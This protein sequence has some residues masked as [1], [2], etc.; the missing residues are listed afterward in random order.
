[1]YTSIAEAVKVYR[2]ELEKMAAW[3]RE[4][5]RENAALP[6]SELVNR[7]TIANYMQRTSKLHGMAAVL[8]LTQEENKQLYASAG[9]PFDFV[10]WL[11]E[12]GIAW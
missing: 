2:A 10:Q 3:T 4:N 6:P 11:K 1:M 7:M 8:G 12:T 9:V 5:K